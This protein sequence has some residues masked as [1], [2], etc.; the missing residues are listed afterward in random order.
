MVT[1]SFNLCDPFDHWLALT[2][3][4]RAF[5]R[6]H[7]LIETD[8]ESQEIESH[9]T[10]SEFGGGCATTVSMDCTFSALP[11]VVGGLSVRTSAVPTSACFVGEVAI[12]FV[13]DEIVTRGF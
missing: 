6:K 1:K 5:I 10:S 8:F 12:R 3:R 4:V 13:P 2:P 11:D 9:A 7:S